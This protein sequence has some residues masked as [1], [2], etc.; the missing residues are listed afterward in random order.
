MFQAD[1][2]RAVNS[3]TELDDVN[4]KIYGIP[5]NTDVN[6]ISDYITL[7]GDAY[8][9]YSNLT[10]GKISASTIIYI[11]INSVTIAKYTVSYR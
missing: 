4:Q 6:K 7:K 11:K 2:K 10:S 9:E 8:I 5:K 1:L 3:G